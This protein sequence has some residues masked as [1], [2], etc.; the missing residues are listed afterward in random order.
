MGVYPVVELIYVTKN[1]GKEKIDKGP[2]N[3]GWS[4]TGKARG[5]LLHAPVGQHPGLTLAHSSTAKG[6][7]LLLPG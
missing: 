1:E 5:T 3:F 7:G 2:E 4:P 6:R